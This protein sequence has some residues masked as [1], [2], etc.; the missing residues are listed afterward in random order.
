MA[1]K[2]TD[3][4]PK[5]KVKK[6]PCDYQEAYIRLRTV[7]DALEIAALR[8]CLKDGDKQKRI[9]RADEL[10]QMIMPVIGTIRDNTLG[11][12]IPAGCGDGYYE[13]NGVCVPYQCPIS[14]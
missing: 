2:K 11:P 12:G 9:K 10:V 3:P 4:N 6:G 1:S 7:M 5:K 14:K 8:Y 13:C